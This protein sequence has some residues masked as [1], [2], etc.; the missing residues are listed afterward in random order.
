MAIEFPTGE[1]DGL[2]NVAT[3]NPDHDDGDSNKRFCLA[4]K[5]F[6]V[7]EQPACNH[8]RDLCDVV[9]DIVQ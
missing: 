7:Q 2:G 8:C 9:Q 4:S 6:V 3:N 1:P 5:I